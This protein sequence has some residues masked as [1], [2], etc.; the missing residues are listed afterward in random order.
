MAASCL[1]AVDQLSDDECCQ[2]N[3]LPG[4]SSSSRALVPDSGG[5]HQRAPKRLPAKKHVLKVKR[6]IKLDARALRYR[7]DGSC[8]C[9]CNCFGP[10]RDQKTFSRLVQE[11]RLLDLMDKMEQDKHVMPST[12]CECI[13]S[14]LIQRTLK[15][16][17]K[18]YIEILKILKSWSIFYP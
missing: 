14:A 8:G 12:H 7:V 5:S 1:Q 15:D 10:F 18:L 11:H 16:L 13:M 17:E 4:G 2:T 9:L 6:D 3:G